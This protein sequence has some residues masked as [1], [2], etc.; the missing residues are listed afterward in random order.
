MLTAT[1]ASNCS[2]QASCE[3]HFLTGSQETSR[4]HRQILTEVPSTTQCAVRYELPSYLTAKY[5]YYLYLT[6]F[7]CLIFYLNRFIF[8]LQDYNL[9]LKCN[10][11]LIL[12]PPEMS[13]HI[14]AQIL[15]Y[16]NSHP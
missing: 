3:Q 2:I 4:T 11:T 15:Y 13:S 5:I 1:T 9:L 10:I 16:C 7:K 12:K 8:F 6:D 14:V